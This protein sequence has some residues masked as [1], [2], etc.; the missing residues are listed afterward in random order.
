MGALLRLPPLVTLVIALAVGAY[1]IYHIVST[2]KA[3]PLAIIALVLVGF[4]LLRSLYRM[5]HRAPEGSESK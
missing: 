1:V 5:W 4:G 3:Q 2:G